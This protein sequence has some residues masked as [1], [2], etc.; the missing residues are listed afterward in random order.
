[1][2]KDEIVEEVRRQREAYVAKFNYDLDAIYRDLKAKER[3]SK[4]RIVSF[5]PR[6]PI[7]PVL[8]KVNKTTRV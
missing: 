2:W 5:P 8:P 7:V 1:M 3:K 4:R 6:K